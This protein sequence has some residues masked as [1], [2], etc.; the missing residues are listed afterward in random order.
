MTTKRPVKLY[1]HPDGAQIYFEPFTP[2]LHCCDELGAA[3]VAI[4][5]LGLIALGHRLIG[6]GDQMRRETGNKAIA[7]IKD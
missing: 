1:D 4:G 7:R 5:P 2:A 6:L 3:S